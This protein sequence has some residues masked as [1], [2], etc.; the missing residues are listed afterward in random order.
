MATLAE[1]TH[2]GSYRP[3]QLPVSMTGMQSMASK[4]W[5][6]FIAMGFMI[7]VISVI[8]GLAVSANA[9]DYYGASKTLRE[10]AETG[11]DLATQKAFIESTKPESTEGRP[12]GQPLK[13]LE[14]A[15]LNLG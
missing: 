5:I 1:V 3:D 12:W 7:V 4:M 10:A 11:S 13:K 15:P 6:P 14:G 2:E 9:A 8:V